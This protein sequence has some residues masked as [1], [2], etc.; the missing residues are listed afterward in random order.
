ML[1]RGS[2]TATPYW[3]PER[4]HVSIAFTWSPLIPALLEVLEA[5]IYSFESQASF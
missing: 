2:A 5:G 4:I 1:C 3:L